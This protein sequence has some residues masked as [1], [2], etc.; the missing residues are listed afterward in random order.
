[1]SEGG[2]FWWQ[3]RLTGWRRNDS[4]E[5][6]QTFLRLFTIINILHV[7]VD[8]IWDGHADYQ[9]AFLISFIGAA[10]LGLLSMVFKAR[11]VFDE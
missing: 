3:D 2:N 10:F 4:W 9:S 5:A 8:A 1:M 11:P 6:S 7:A